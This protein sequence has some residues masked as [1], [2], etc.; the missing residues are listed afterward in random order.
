MKTWSKIA[1]VIYVGNAL[2]GTFAWLTAKDIY[3]FAALTIAWCF[4]AYGLGM[5]QRYSA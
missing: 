5:L 4:A 1:L 3:G 2:Y